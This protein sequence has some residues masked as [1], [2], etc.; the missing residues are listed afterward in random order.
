VADT[1]GKRLQRS[2]KY[3]IF[4][5]GGERWQKLITGQFCGFQDVSQ[6]ESTICGNSNG[7]SNYAHRIKALGNSVVPQIPEILGHA[8]MKAEGF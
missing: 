4:G 7:V 3:G 6:V 2:E 5:K 1:N 8:I